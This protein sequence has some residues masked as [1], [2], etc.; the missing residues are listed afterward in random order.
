MSKPKCFGIKFTEKPVKEFESC[1]ICH[2][3][4]ECSNV[5]LKKCFGESYNYSEDCIYC[6]LKNKCEERFSKKDLIEDKFKSISETKEKA[7]RYEDFMPNRTSSD[8]SKLIDILFDGDCNLDEI[9]NKFMKRMN[10]KKIDEIHK[11][12]YA[13]SKITV[14]KKD[15]N[16]KLKI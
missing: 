7:N 11:M 2:Y 15:G 4:D 1:K 16:G 9:F 10:T 14:I 6:C 8:Y 5:K 3:H 12:L 13:I